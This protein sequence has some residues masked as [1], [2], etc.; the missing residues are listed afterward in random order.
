LMKKKLKKKK[1]DENIK[2]ESSKFMDYKVL[3]TS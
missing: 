1:I 3:K 2:N